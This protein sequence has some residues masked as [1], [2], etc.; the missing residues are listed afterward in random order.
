MGL[1]IPITVTSAS[2]EMTEGIT[3][4][5]CGCPPVI[6]IRAFMGDSD[7][8]KRNLF[9]FILGRDGLVAGVT[10]VLLGVVVIVLA[11]S[12]TI[13]SMLRGQSAQGHQCHGGKVPGRVRS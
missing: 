1:L 9:L 11:T 7:F 3:H 8:R 5:D 12:S 10:Q 6:W 13:S 4:G 2:V